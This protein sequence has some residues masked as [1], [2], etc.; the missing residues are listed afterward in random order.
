MLPVTGSA[1]RRLIEA[2]ALSALPNAPVQPEERVRR[3]RTRSAFATAL[4]RT[5]ELLAPARTG[6]AP[7]PAVRW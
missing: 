4:R 6:A 3:R 5:A 2:E 1:A 7:T